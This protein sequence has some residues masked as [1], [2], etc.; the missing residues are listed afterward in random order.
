MPIQD[1]YARDC[2]SHVLSVI[3]D[4]ESIK[5]EN[6][7]LNGTIHTQTIGEPVN[8]ATVRC[9]GT[10]DQWEN[11]SDSAAKSAT[12]YVDFEGHFYDGL[13]TGSPS[14]SLYNRGPRATRLYEITFSMYVSE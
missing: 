8:T 6:R 12:V 3:P 10:Y 4:R 13:I 9:L 5:I 7:L 14:R 11:L 1:A 2:A